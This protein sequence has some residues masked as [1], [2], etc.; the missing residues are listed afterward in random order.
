MSS[1]VAAQPLSLRVLDM[2]G[3]V[4]AHLFEGERPA[5]QQNMWL[6]LS[7]VLPKKGLYLLDI[8]VGEEKVGKRFLRL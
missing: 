7:A 5:G 1:S 6:D 3:Q 4:V 2:N 8:Q